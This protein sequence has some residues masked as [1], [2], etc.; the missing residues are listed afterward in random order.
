MID[1][2]SGGLH[3]AIP[4]EGYALCAVP[5]DQKEQMRI[6]LNILSAAVEEE[7]SVTEKSLLFTLD[8]CEASVVAMERQAMRRMLLSL[9]AVHN[10]VFAMSQDMEGLVETSSNLASIHLEGDR[11]VVT[12]SQRSSVGSAC[13]HMASVVRAA[14]ELGGAEVLTNEGYPGW[15]L[16]PNSEIVKIAKE[17]YV[18]LFGKEPL[19]LAIHAGLECGLFSEKYTNLDMVSFG[20]TQRGVH[21][22]DERLLIPTVQMVWDHLLD[23]LKRV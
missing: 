23:I 21:S 4:R 7:Y 19:V 16:N 8:S 18:S 9:Q 20:P 14:F 13:Q 15:K 2:Q 11:V 6:D 10:G 5:A 1:I 12:T 3:N 22:P 17:S